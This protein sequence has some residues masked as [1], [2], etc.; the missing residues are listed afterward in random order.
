M[1]LL[2]VD[3]LSVHFGDKKAPFRAVDRV[4]YEVNEGEVLG[5]VGESGSGKSVSSLAIMGLIDFPGR[6]MANSL[7]FNGHNLLDL[8]PKEKQKIVG[9]DVAMIFQDAMTSLNPSYTV[10]YQIMEAL[11]VH[12]DGSKAWRKERAIEL[13]TMVGIPDPTSRLDVYPHQLSGGMSQRVMIAMA[14]A[15]NPKLL[16]ADEPTTALDVTIQAQ[17]IDLLLELQ[18]KENMA[19]ILITHDLA[20]VAESAHR[21]IVMYAGQVVEEGKSEQIFKSPLHPYTQALLKALPEFAE[22]K[23]RLQSLPGVVPGK[24]DRPQGCLLNPRCPYATD[25]CRQK[26]PELRTVNGRQVKCHTPLNESGLP[27]PI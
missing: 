19:L 27:Q 16:I 21:I 6:V 23:S 22:G 25:L 13:L 12:Q 15:C 7:R 20:L 17:I 8:K 3:E 9:A 11:K 10:G 5:I 18:R 26:E 1:A 4:S 2:K 24:Y 14:I